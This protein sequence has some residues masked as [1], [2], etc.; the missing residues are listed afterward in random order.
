MLYFNQR[1]HTHILS[2]A[3]MGSQLASIRIRD[4]M[5]DESDDLADIARVYFDGFSTTV[6]HQLIYPGGASASAR[7][8][9]ICKLRNDFSANPTSA[10]PVRLYL[11]VAELM[12]SN[13]DDEKAKPEII[14]MAKWKFVKQPLSPEVWDVRDK[15]QMT[16]EELGDGVNLEVWRKFIGGIHQIRRGMMRGDRCLR[17]FATLPLFFPCAT[18]GSVGGAW[19]VRL[20]QML[21][22]C[23][24]LGTLVC[25][26]DYR[27]LGAASA[28][29]QWG[30]QLADEERVPAF[31]EAS[32]PGYPLYKSFGFEDMYAQ[33]LALEGTSLGNEKDWG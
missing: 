14:A 29:L 25:H 8:K 12:P 6:M 11:K 26:P 15:D 2:T 24:D 28:L 30:V 31:L 32:P 9:F 18:F 10:S 20:H 23:I 33:D 19:V 1:R 3:T 17:E 7:E 5:L 21:M 16:Q 22:K 4:A 13:G 27:G